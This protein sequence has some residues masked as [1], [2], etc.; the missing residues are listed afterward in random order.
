MCFLPSLSHRKR[1]ISLCG[2]GLSG[3]G[4]SYSVPFSVFLLS[5]QLH[6]R[7]CSNLPTCLQLCLQTERAL[8]STQAAEQPT[9]CPF[10]GSEDV[11]H[12]MGHRTPYQTPPVTDACTLHAKEYRWKENMS[13]DM[14][15]STMDMSTCH[16]TWICLHV[17]RHG[18][19]YMSPDMD[20][21]TWHQTWICLHVARHGYVYMSP[22]MDMSTCHQTWICLHIH[23]VVSRQVPLSLAR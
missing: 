21:S 18:Y 8:R 13:P 2:R 1:T 23:S 11:L 19:V 16:Q 20:M 5:H 22:D 15:M 9:V 4:L 12:R 6:P 7:L 14:D 17:A 3:R 10:W